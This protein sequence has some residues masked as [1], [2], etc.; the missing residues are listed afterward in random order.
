MPMREGRRN[1]WG[2]LAIG[3]ALSLI[4]TVSYVSSHR[5]H[6]FIWLFAP[7]CLALGLA[8]LVEPRIALA[9]SPEAGSLDLPRWARILGPVLLAGGVAVG[10]ALMHYTF[11]E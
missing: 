8:G 4:D 5:Y 1:A 10:W 3:V 6:P 11:G 9:V 2:I 7:G